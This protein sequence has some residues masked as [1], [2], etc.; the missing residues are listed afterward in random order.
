MIDLN[1]CPDCSI[2]NDL[3]AS[4]LTTEQVNDY[5]KKATCGVELTCPRQRP[6]GDE[7]TN[8]RCAVYPADRPVL[9]GIAVTAI[10]VQVEQQSL[11]PE[12]PG[13]V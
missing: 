3:R 2:A 13:A 10:A 7:I 9:R 12:A 4:G 11:M 8:N 5:V 1:K 6:N